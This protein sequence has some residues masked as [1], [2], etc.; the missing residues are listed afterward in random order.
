MK[1]TIISLFLMV[2][3]LGQSLCYAN[4][5]N[6]GAVGGYSSLNAS[7]QFGTSNGNLG[8]GVRAGLN[9]LR[10]LDISAEYT[11]TSIGDGSNFT[12]FDAALDY[13][14]WLHEP[15]RIFIGPKVGMGWI[16]AQNDRGASISYGGEFGLDYSVSPSLSFGGEF[17]YLHVNAPTINNVSGNSGTLRQGMAALKIWF[18]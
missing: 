5:F 17:N 14:I 18:Y 15:V 11:K 8:Y 7:D 6:V 10:N 1:L 4:G 16:S 9:F 3:L 13:S 2:L 12:I